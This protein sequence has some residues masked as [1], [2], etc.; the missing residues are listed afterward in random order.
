MIKRGD[1]IWTL[2]N[3]EFEIPLWLIKKYNADLDFNA[4]VPS[5]KLLIPVIEKIA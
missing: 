1:N 3:Q 2:A 5:Q 4:L